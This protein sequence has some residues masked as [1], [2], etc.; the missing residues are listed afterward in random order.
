MEGNE[1]I[2]LTVGHGQV[3]GYPADFLVQTIREL[4]ITDPME[5]EPAL[6]GLGL[7]PKLTNFHFVTSVNTP[8]GPMIHIPVQISR[9]PD[10]R[11]S[12]YFLREGQETVAGYLIS[13]KGEIF[14]RWVKREKGSK[15]PAQDGDLY[16]IQIRTIAGHVV[17]DGVGKLVVTDAMY[18]EGVI[19]AYG[20]SP[21]PL[22][23][24]KWSFWSF[25]LICEG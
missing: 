2:A 24:C 1:T 21:K 17:W 9:K 25:S 5:L 7:A 6:A 13:S 16:R 18:G 22:W 10:G 19:Q 12:L 15:L 20:D 14:E 3:T 11:V 23:S 8:L 4:G